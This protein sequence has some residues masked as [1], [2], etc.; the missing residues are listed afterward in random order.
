[1][2]ICKAS[3][4]VTNWE[5]YS[6][7][8][9]MNCSGCPCT[10]RASRA[11]GGRRLPGHNKHDTHHGCSSSRGAQGP[12]Q[13]HGL[14]SFLS[15]LSFLSCPQANPPSPVKWDYTVQSIDGTEV[16]FSY[17]SWEASAAT[18]SIFL[19]LTAGVGKEE[20]KSRGSDQTEKQRKAGKEN[21]QKCSPA[22]T[23]SHPVI[24]N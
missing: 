17:T 11:G 21:A 1:M 9:N 5:V 12:P 2:I 18:P 15:F 8:H 24:H 16:S 19:L 4:E 14:L 20:E 10:C 13:S 3:R 22:H 6:V 7:F 23:E